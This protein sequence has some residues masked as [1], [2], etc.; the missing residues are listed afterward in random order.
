MENV[1]QKVLVTFVMC[2]DRIVQ[3]FTQPQYLRI[4]NFSTATQHVVMKK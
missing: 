4:E 1:R 2:A 3:Y